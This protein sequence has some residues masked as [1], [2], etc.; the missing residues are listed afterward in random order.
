M[1]ADLEIFMTDTQKKYYN[2]MKQ[3]SR[4]KPPKPVPKPKVH[5]HA[6]S[7]GN[8]LYERQAD[9]ILGK[10]EQNI[11][12]QSKIGLNDIRLE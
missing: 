2:T 9:Y 10:F 12:E 6:F 5:L 4:R 8:R 3:F 11:I 7:S 1:G